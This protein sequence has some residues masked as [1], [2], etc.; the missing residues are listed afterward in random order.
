MSAANSMSALP[1][2]W[3]MRPDAVVNALFPWCIKSRDAEK[4]HWNTMRDPGV[5]EALRVSRN[6]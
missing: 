6:V 2:P 5:V 1:A 4:R 3:N